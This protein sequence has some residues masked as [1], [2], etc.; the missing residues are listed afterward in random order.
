MIGSTTFSLCFNRYRDRKL[1]NAGTLTIGG[2]KSDFLT[3]PMVYFKNT[4]ID[5]KYSSIITNIYLREG[6]GESVNVEADQKII[7]VVFRK[8]SAN[9]GP[10]TVID[11][12]YPGTLLNYRIGNAFKDEWFSITNKQFFSSPVSLS[13]QELRKLPTILVQLQSSLEDD[14]F[15]DPNSVV[16]MVGDEL[17]PVSIPNIIKYVTSFHGTN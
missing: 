7:R 13:D 14:Q 5:G 8:D 6:G 1:D 15:P 16:G 4:G 10:G 11:T 12:T 3:S 2:Y 17:D 9:S